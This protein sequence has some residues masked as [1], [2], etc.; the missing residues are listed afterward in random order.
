MV[1]ARLAIIFMFLVR[2]ITLQGQQMTWSE[3]IE[4]NSR[5][6]FADILLSDSGYTLIRSREPDLS[7]KIY[8][9]KYTD[10]LS[11][12][13]QTKVLPGKKEG[14]IVSYFNNNQEF[15]VFRSIYSLL[16]GYNILYLEKYSPL[17]SKPFFYKE[18]CRSA[19]KNYGDKGDFLITRSEDKKN[20][21]CYYTTIDDNGNDIV[22]LIMLD[23]TAKMVYY[24]VFTQIYQSNA[25]ELIQIECDYQ[26]NAYLLYKE[27][28]LIHQRV[29]DFNMYKV[30]VFEPAENKLYI[31]VI[32]SGVHDILDLYM[33]LQPLK[34][35]L[36]LGGFYNHKSKPGIGGSV[37]IRT[38]LPE[39]K[40]EVAAFNNFTDS[41]RVKALG[42]RQYIINST[43]K[44]YIIRHQ[45]LRSDGG[46]ILI[47]ERVFTNQQNYTYAGNGSMQ[48]SYRTVYNFNEIV[49]VSTNADGAIKWEQPIRKTQSTVNDGGVYSGFSWIT[50]SDRI[51]FHFNKYENGDYTVMEYALMNNGE[52]LEREFLKSDKEDYTMIPSESKQVSAKEMLFLVKKDS[53][54]YILKASFPF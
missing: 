22:N 47:A 20:Y 8:I 21:L 44:D 51:L 40:I 26:Q 52:L 35:T 11:L 10:S 18:V 4:N 12:L 36:V 5:L 41:F 53:Q 1:I 38:S 28:D 29:N 25:S 46:A 45:I 43:L 7:E 9:E 14:F 17:T 39:A 34:K 27:P 13:S 54:K 42:E 49:V 23:S 50:F 24:R 31:S 2:V 48:T 19:L 33:T 37:Y 32:D 3:P 30:A 6:Q 16:D 15:W